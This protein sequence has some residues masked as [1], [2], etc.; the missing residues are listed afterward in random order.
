[1]SR[2]AAIVGSLGLRAVVD[3]DASINVETDAPTAEPRFD[4]NSI[5]MID[6]DQHYLLFG[7]AGSSS[8]VFRVQFR[9]RRGAYQLMAAARD[10]GS[11]WAQTPW[12]SIT[13]G[14]H[15][16]E[17]SW[18]AASAPGANDGAMALTIDGGQGASV[19]GLD[20]DSRRIDR[21]RL[22]AASGIDP[23][24]RG[25]YHFDGLTTTR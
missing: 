12:L 19:P 21:L 10:D 16:V 25:T 3:D 14:P 17:L 18:R 8:G 4:P 22:G 23:G 11:S 15:L 1:V 13:D 6:G 7:F 20:N 5:S 2:A 24:T 9:S